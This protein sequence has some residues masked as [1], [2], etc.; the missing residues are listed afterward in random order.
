MENKVNITMQKTYF[1]PLPQC[2]LNH[3]RQLHPL[4]QIQ[5]PPPVEQS[6]GKFHNDNLINFSGKDPWIEQYEDKLSGQL[7]DDYSASV[8]SL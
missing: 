5:V 8:S 7:G 4:Q 1:L 2:H 6:K 3:W